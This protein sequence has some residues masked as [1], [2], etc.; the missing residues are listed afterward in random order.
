MQ[1]WVYLI[2]LFLGC[3]RATT[4][5]KKV[6]TQT[7]D[8]YWGRIEPQ[9]LSRLATLLK[10]EESG[11]SI[12][13]SALFTPSPSLYLSEGKD[14][15]LILNEIGVDALLLSPEI[16]ALGKE[17]VKNIS[18]SSKFYLL[19]ANIFDKITSKPLC[20]SYFVKTF[21]GVRVA[22]IGV[23]PEFTTHISGIEIR[24]CNRILKKL[25]KLMRM[26]ADIVGVV[27]TSK[28][29]IPEAD[30]SLTLDNKIKRL[31]LIISKRDIVKREEEEIELPPPDLRV[32]EILSHYQK[33]QDSVVVKL[34]NTLSP[35]DLERV[36]SEAV[37]EYTPA[38]GIIMEKVE[39]GLPS[40]DI[41]AAKLHSLLPFSG[42]IRILKCSPS[43]I[44]EVKKDPR[45]FLHLKSEGFD[46]VAVI[47]PI[48]KDRD[49][50]LSS[51]SLLK[52]LILYLNERY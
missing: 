46:K 30:F 2:L 18:D 21:D 38:K 37:L 24:K 48:L 7:I 14:L 11:I 13:S 39:K 36:I 27:S 42:H 33:I 28:L 43:E 47:A 29:Y 20:H 6:S 22:V 32:E 25:I 23:C 49:F 12:L 34:N 51:L 3:I 5:A 35:Q 41:T 50:E 15:T 16:L 9:S 10:G 31:R 4:Q 8:I 44:E 1:K 45:F 26:R 17:I 19:G 40:G 52:L